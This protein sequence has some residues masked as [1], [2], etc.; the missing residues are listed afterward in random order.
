M[1]FFDRADGS[2]QPSGDEGFLTQAER[3][4][5]WADNEYI[6]YSDFMR[7]LYDDEK[8][9]Q[10]VENI[11]NEDWWRKLHNK[12]PAHGFLISE[13]MEKLLG[14][15]WPEI[16]DDA[17]FLY[18]DLRLL[19]N[20]SR[21]KIRDNLSAFYKDHLE[22]LELFVVIA[23]LDLVMELYSGK[24]DKNFIKGHEDYII[25]NEKYDECFVKRCMSGL[26]DI[27]EGFP[28]A[29]NGVLIYLL[30]GAQKT[31]EQSGKAAEKIHNPS[32]PDDDM[33]SIRRI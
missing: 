20:Q 15:R 26:V 33:P 7:K 3:E 24:F 1:S 17:N 32:P 27:N 14:K 29:L 13:K 16:Q 22:A 19:R 30:Q 5:I 9:Y 25:E 12:Q 6:K 10:L 28:L 23:C 8:L 21:N 11:K 2:Q 18:S 31:N 4:E